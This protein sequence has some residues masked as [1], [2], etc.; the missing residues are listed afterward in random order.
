MRNKFIDNVRG[1]FEVLES[2]VNVP[3][4]ACFMTLTNVLLFNLFN[5][6]NLLNLLIPSLY[7]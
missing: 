6:L 7:F 3:M 4:S 5:L 2:A 1:R